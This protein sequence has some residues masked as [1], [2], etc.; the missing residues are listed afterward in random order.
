MHAEFGK[1]AGSG[2]PSRAIAGTMYYTVHIV[3][4]YHR[5]HVEQPGEMG[6]YLNWV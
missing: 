4:T 3:C 1:L 2:V 6:P 5:E